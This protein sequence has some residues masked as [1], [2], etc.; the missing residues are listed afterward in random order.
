MT[1]FGIGKVLCRRR[2]ETGKFYRIPKEE[3]SRE[4]YETPS[5]VKHRNNEIVV[6]VDGIR[7]CKKRV[8]VDINGE[9][10]YISLKE[11]ILG[12]YK[13]YKFE[14]ICVFDINSN[15]FMTRPPRESDIIFEGKNRRYI[16]NCDESEIDKLDQPE[17]I[18][19]YLKENINKSV[20]MPI[21]I[22]E[23]M[24]LLNID[25]KFDLKPSNIRSAS[26]RSANTGCV[27]VYEISTQK[28]IKITKEEYYNNKDRY[29]AT[30]A[31]LKKYLSQ[32]VQ[33][34]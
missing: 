32:Q 12:N 4:E 11:F 1:T 28:T 13:K 20:L 19:N 34:S 10:R 2:G 21:V 26:I 30:G 17:I 18:K 5:E 27:N 6:E 9:P 7:I 14:S 22:F 31:K 15:K 3:Y 8:L 23:N 16:F 24:K 29:I 25:V 33:Q